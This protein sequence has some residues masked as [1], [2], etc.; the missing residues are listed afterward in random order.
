MTVV[1]VSPSAIDAI[2]EHGPTPDDARPPLVRRVADGTSRLV[3][4][5]LRGDPKSRVALIAATGDDRAALEITR[6]GRELA[7]APIVSIVNDAARG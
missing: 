5:D 3:L 7:Y 1:D 6:L 4:E 2:H